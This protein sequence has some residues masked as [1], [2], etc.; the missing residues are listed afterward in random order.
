[1]LFYTKFVNTMKQEPMMEQLL[2]ISGD[3]LGA[4]EGAWD[5][6]YEPE[7]RSVLEQVLTR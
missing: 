7:A 5:Y 1:V 3:R 4:P 2:P 6:I